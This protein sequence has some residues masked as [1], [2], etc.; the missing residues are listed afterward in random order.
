MSPIQ[1]PGEPEV[2]NFQLSRQNPYSYCQQF[3]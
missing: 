1:S 3:N 2:N